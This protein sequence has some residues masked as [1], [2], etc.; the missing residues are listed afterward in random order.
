MVKRYYNRQKK[1]YAT[2]ARGVQY[3]HFHA[4]RKEAAAYRKRLRKRGYKPH[5]DHDYIGNY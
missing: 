3:I 5:T 1:T 2:H 4:T